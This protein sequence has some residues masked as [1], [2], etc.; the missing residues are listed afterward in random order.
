M[1]DHLYTNALEVKNALVFIFGEHPW[2]NFDPKRIY[3]GTELDHQFLIL[4]LFEV[5]PQFIPTGTIEF[6]GELHTKHGQSI[7]LTN[8]STKAISYIAKL[9]GATEF[10]MDEFVFTIPPMSDYNFKV[11]YT[12]RFARRSEAIL[13]IQSKRCTLSS[14]NILSFKLSASPSKLQPIKTFNAESSVYAIPATLIKIDVK[15]IFPQNANFKVQIFQTTMKPAVESTAS[16]LNQ[17]VIIPS[18]PS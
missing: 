5:L 12:G 7:E 3:R 18:S 1:D 6:S 17:S 9:H 10:S 14:C 11:E 4:F 13:T 15:N 8:S 2:Q 16:F